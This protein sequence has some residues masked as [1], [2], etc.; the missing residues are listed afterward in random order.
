[1]NVAK[2]RFL[3]HKAAKGKNDAEAGRVSLHQESVLQEFRLWHLEAA[4]HPQATCSIQV[5]RDRLDAISCVF[6]GR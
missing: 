2:S 1:M 5:P 3:P 4:E 6:E